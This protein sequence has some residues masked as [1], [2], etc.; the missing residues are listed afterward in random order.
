MARIVQFSNHSQTQSKIIYYTLN[1]VF[2]QLLRDKSVASFLLGKKVY[3]SDQL[4]CY[5]YCFG[6]FTMHL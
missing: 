6:A 4:S 1:T 5:V 3:F 2:Y